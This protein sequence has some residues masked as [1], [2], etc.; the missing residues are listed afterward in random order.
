MTLELRPRCVVGCYDWEKT[1]R[2]EMRL[3]LVLETDCA[4]AGREDDLEKG[5]NYEPLVTRLMEAAEG[6]DFDLVEALA[7]TAA[8]ICVV[9]FKVPRV[10]VAVTKREALPGLDAVTIEISRGTEDYPPL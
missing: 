8:R 3:R 6:G 1:L 7:E 10:E 5:L 9:E 4:A 2:R